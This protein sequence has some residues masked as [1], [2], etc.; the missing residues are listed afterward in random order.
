MADDV[1]TS[2][3][4]CEEEDAELSLSSCSL[5]IP[6]VETLTGNRNS[7]VLQTYPRLSLQTL[8]SISGL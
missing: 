3:G 7:L 6:P 5:G 2:A 4:S 8:L 1:A